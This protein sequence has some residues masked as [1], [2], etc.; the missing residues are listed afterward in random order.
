MFRALVS[1]AAVVVA[2]TAV[3]ECMAH[4]VTVK[5]E[6]GQEIRLHWHQNRA[7]SPWQTVTLKS[8]QKWTW[9]DDSS[10]FFPI[11]VNIGHQ[12][13]AGVPGS[14]TGGT[15]WHL[16]PQGTPWNGRSPY[17]LK[18]RTDDTALFV[19]FDNQGKRDTGRSY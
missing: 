17:T 16:Y 6:T 19:V 3:V 2:G 15:T 10:S 8:G 7:G 9:Q 11:S 14:F 4:E 5:N 12:P 18:A 13:V 1:V